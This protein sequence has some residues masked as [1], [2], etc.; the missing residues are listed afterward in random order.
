MLALKT[1]KKSAESSQESALLFS[2][3]QTFK[4][5][6]RNPRDQNSSQ[7]YIY[8]RGKERGKGMVQLQCL[9]LLDR[10]WGDSGA[11]FPL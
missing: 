3:T 8:L 1:T 9:P 2:Y 11:V 4:Y 10:P 7:T 5:R 6:N